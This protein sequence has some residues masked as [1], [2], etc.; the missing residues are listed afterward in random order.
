MKVKELEDLILS[1][2]VNVNNSSKTIKHT[3]LY[4]LFNSVMWTK[5][6][7]VLL[8]LFGKMS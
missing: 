2:Q 7:I 1:I 6:D 4:S 8:H 3:I 5:I